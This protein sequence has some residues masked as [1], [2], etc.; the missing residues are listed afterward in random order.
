[1]S[2][3]HVK[4]EVWEYDKDH[5]CEVTICLLTNEECISYGYEAECSN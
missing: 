2:C 1:M 4:P 5:V 3:K